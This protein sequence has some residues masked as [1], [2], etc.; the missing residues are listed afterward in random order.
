MNKLVEE[1]SE[2][3]NIKLVVMLAM[4]DHFRSHVLESTAESR[5]ARQARFALTPALRD[6]FA[7]AKVCNTQVAILVNQYILRL[8]ISIKDTLIV[9]VF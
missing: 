8:Q 7:K 9:H 1:N 4:I 3:P 2:S 6:Y 5:R